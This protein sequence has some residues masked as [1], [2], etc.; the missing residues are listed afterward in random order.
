MSKFQLINVNKAPEEVMG[1]FSTY[2]EA[3]DAKRLNIG[4]VCINDMAI[5]KDGIEYGLNG[6]P[7]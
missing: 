1:E 4:Q 3:R 5:E 6:E 7:L 2:G